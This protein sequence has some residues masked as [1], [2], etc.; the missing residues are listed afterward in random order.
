MLAARLC[1]HRISGLRSLA[2][3]SRTPHAAQ[4]C[5]VQRVCLARPCS[6]AAGFE[7][8]N[9][10][11]GVVQDEPAVLEAPPHAFLAYESPLVGRFVNMMMQ[12]GKKMIARKLLMG[13]FTKL[14]DDGKDPLVVFRDA[15]ENVRPMMEVRTMKTGMVPYPLT[16]R[17]A[18]GLSMK[19]IIHAAR[20]RSVLGGMST[21]L[22]LE[23]LQAE[24]GKGSAVARREA[25]HKLALQNQAAAHFRWRAA[26]TTV[27]GAID[28]DKK[29]YRPQGRR[30]IK[31]LKSAL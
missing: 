12:D 22:Y 30:S 16:P 20:K 28:M 21:K 23:L 29:S 6:S 9:G 7:S 26:G 2:R 13:A 8:T 5:A 14:R 18:E 24:Q 15:L 3:N 11:S 10:L 19:W 4:I 17:R 25:V 1:L 31:E 27:Q